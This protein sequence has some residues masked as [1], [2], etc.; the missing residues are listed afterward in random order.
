MISESL[1]GVRLC[2]RGFVGDEY[3]VAGLLEYQ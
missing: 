1:I 3:G 2:A